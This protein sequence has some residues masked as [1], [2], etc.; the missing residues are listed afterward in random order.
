[1]VSCFPGRHETLSGEK[2][3]A[4]IDPRLPPRSPVLYCLQWGQVWSDG[5]AILSVMITGVH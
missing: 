4:G 5:T 3:R 2:A 1:M